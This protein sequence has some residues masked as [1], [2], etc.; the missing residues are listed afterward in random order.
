MNKNIVITIIVL[1]LSVSYVSAQFTVQGVVSDET[2]MPLPGC[3]VHYGKTC[4]I[5][6]GDGAFTIE[7]KALTANLTFTFMGYNSLDTLVRSNSSLDIHMIPSHEMVQ[8]ISVK[9]NRIDTMKSRKNEVVTAEFMAQNL[10]STFIKSLERLPGVNAMD[11]G[12]NASKPIIRGMGFNRVVVSENGVKQEGQQWGADHGLEI[13]PFNIETAEIVKGASGIEYG[14]DAIG[15]YINIS[16]D[17]VPLPNTVSGEASFL[18]KSVNATFGASGAV[19]ARGD[20]HYVKVRASAID[21]GDYKVPTDQIIYLDRIVPIYNG[22]LKNTA[23]KEYDAYLQYG[24]LHEAFKSS[25]TISNVYQKSG[26]FPGAHGVPDA[27]RVKHDGDYR[28]IDF[29]YQV[30]NHTKVMSNNKFY[31]NSGELIADLAYQFNN[32]QELSEFHTHYGNQSPPEIDPDLE[33]AFRLSTYTANVKYVFKETEKHAISIGSQSQYRDNKV[34]GYSFLMPQYQSLSTGLFAKDTYTINDKFKMNVGLRFDY[35]NI[36]TEAYFD[37]ILYDYFIAKGSSAEEAS[38]YAQRSTELHK[39]YGDYSWLVGF[40]YEPANNWITRF[41]VGKAFRTPTAVELSSNGIHH[42]SFRHELGNGELDSEKGYY[43]DANLEFNN[44]LWSFS[45]SP[46]LYYFTNFLYLRPTGE[47]SSLPHAGQIY[48]YDQ[49]A[50]I[51]SG[52]ELSA[53]RQ[54]GKFSADF[55]LEYVYNQQVSDDPSQRYPLPFT[56]PLNGFIEIDYAAFA[57]SKVLKQSRFFVNT[58]FASKQENVAR[59]EEVTDGYFSLGAGFSTKVRLSNKEVDL[60]LQGF[61]LL[62]AKYYNHMSFYRQIEIPEQGR[63]IQLLVKV[64]F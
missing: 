42:G 34:G 2:G 35:S 22:R 62:D 27:D 57:H 37:P 30:A 58:R 54:L 26:F 64:P 6:N 25:I 41:N 53:R 55:T 1:F 15:G 24:Y 39:D 23:G 50:A 19:E 40:V 60:V 36:D 51:V 47:W 7:A 43:T 10:S 18:T 8:E 38:F 52:L 44:S 49:T 4:N 11:I 29:P 9:G 21:Y 48:A 3:H 32:R 12:A 31:F 46:Y 61:N 59:N 63:N 13:D 56:P 45:V 5:T 16:N 28:N 20:K 14:S 17:K 33:L